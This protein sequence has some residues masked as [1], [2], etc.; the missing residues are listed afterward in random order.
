MTRRRRRRLTLALLLAL[1][2]HAACCCSAFPANWRWFHAPAP[3]QFD[4]VLLPPVEQTQQLQNRRPLR[5]NRQ[6]PKRPERPRSH[7]SIAVPSPAA[8]AVPL[9]PW[10]PNQR[11]N[12]RRKVGG[13]TACSRQD[14]ATF[15]A[16]G[17]TH[18]S[19]KINRIR[20]AG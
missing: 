20:K 1:G 8:Y 14:R 12:R 15:P 17:Q 2:L 3:R 6:N 18:R 11:H 16:T 19:T 10:S 7:P 4:V 13:Q 5:R 9:P